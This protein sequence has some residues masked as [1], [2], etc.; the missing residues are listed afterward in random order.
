MLA[1]LKMLVDEELRSKSRLWLDRAL[2]IFE[3]AKLAR[4]FLQLTVLILK[5]FL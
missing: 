1:F 4:D 5:L 2:V 3:L